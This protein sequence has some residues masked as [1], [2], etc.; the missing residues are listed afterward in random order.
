MLFNFFMIQALTDD[1][2][3]LHKN[4]NCGFP[5]NIC[6]LKGNAEVMFLCNPKKSSVNVC[7]MKILKDTVTKKVILCLDNLDEK[8]L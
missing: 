5:L 8:N 1:F 3:G 2:W 7:L 4:M 6:V